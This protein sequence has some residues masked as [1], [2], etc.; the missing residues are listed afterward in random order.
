M[1]YFCLAV[2]PLLMLY[3]ELVRYFELETGARRSELYQLAGRELLK[4]SEYAEDARFFHAVLKNEFSTDLHSQGEQELKV[5]VARLKNDYPGVFS[6]IFWDRNGDVMTSLSDDTRY[7]FLL[8]KL[9]LML[10][11][12]RLDTRA[13]RHVEAGFGDKYNRDLRMLRQFLGPFITPEGLTRPF[14]DAGIAACFQMHARGDRTLGWYEST[15]NYSVL[16]YVSAEVRGALTGPR[17]LCQSLQGKWPEMS[18]YLLDER[19]A[20]LEPSAGGTVSKDILINFGKFKKLAPREHLESDSHFYAFQKLNERWWGVA[21]IEKSSIGNVASLAGGLLARTVMAALILLFVAGCYFLVHDNPL[22]SVRVKLASVFAYTIFI[23]AL[24]FGVVAFDYLKQQEKQ[25]V[26]EYSARSFQLLTSIDSQFKGYLH[27]RATE[28]NLVVEKILADKSAEEVNKLAASFSNTIFSQFAPDTLVIADNSG[29]D[30]LNAE[31]ARTL[32]DDHLRKNAAEELIAYLNADKDKLHLPSKGVAEGFLLSFPLNY[33]RLLPFTLSSTTFISYLN[34]VR[35][36]DDNRFSHLIQIFWHEKDVHLAF[37]RQIAAKSVASNRQRLFISFIETGKI[38]PQNE[39]IPG[40]AAFTEKVRQQGPSYEKLTDCNGKVWL[41]AGQAGTGLG[42]AILTVLVD[43]ELLQRDVGRL[44]NRIWS[45]V[46]WSVL[47][48]L[49]LLYILGHYLIMPIKALADGVDMVRNKNYSYR[50]S[51]PQDNELGRLGHS[52]DE[53]LENLQE[54]EIARTVQESL[55]PQDSLD[56]ASYFVVARTRSM[57]SMGGDYYDFIVDSDNNAAILM[58]DVA[59]HGIQAALM[60]AM[61]KSALLLNDSACSEPEVIMSALNRTFCTLRK[62]SITTMMTGQIISISCTGAISLLNAGHCPPLFISSSREITTVCNHALPFGFA[63]R[64]K[65][66]S[67]PIAMSAGDIMILYS[68][69]IL[70]CANR[71]GRMLGEEG[72]AD[73]ARNCYDTDCTRYL[74]NL[75]NA[76]DRWAASQQDDITFVMIRR[77]EVK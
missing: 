65:F 12:V 76:Y 55:L 77:K 26:S 64:R 13:G 35:S 5:R 20:E 56:L 19:E 69:G 67:M 60:M 66:E 18:F 28:I 40:L 11:A 58:A 30:I 32:K 59:G 14:L 23:P 61:A 1:L 49:S 52:I 31:Y 24:V 17:K 72:F 7:N 9:N 10:D 43:H 37:F 15:S 70:E 36:S 68:D 74:D 6:F 45:L 51:M 46:G 54:L 34:L 2:F 57:T 63:P 3:V 41:A 73:L 29:K 48:I 4:L 71:Q 21:A 25:A 39:D 27:D 75:F 44:T 50:I 53:S 33:R 16:A 22:H 38:W 42:S 8:R 47:V 62:S